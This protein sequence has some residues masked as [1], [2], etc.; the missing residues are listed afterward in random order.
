MPDFLHARTG[1]ELAFISLSRAAGRHGWPR[2]SR[3]HLDDP[4]HAVVDS[5]E[6]RFKDL[7]GPVHGIANVLR[8]ILETT[9]EVDPLTVLRKTSIDLHDVI[10]LHRED[11]VHALEVAPLQTM[12]AMRAQIH[13]EAPR[14]LHSG[15]VSGTIGRRQPRGSDPQIRPSGDARTQEFGGEGASDDVPRTDEQNCIRPRH[16]LR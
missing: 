2:C 12:R 6:A 8:I 10:D 3:K 15:R 9:E 1:P 4:V 5:F 7:L 14:T 16:P 13:P 11:N